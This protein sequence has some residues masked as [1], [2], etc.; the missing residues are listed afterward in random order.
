MSAPNFAATAF[1]TARSHVADDD[2]RCRAVGVFDASCF[3][4][5]RD[6]MARRAKRRYRRAQFMEDE[7]YDEAV[8]DADRRAAVSRGVYD[9][10][11][12]FRHAPQAVASVTPADAVMLIYARR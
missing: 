11:A 12:C 4:S 5:A 9:D 3:A 8:D 10:D 1:A 6:D 2:L 7:V